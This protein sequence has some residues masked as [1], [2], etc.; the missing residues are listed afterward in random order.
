MAAMA[1]STIRRLD[2]FAFSMAISSS[3]GRG[4]P[5]FTSPAG[6]RLTELLISGPL[7]AAMNGSHDGASGGVPPQP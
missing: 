1:F 3:S 7:L 6:G 5:N 4:G 2:S